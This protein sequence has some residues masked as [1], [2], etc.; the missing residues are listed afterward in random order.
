VETLNPDFVVWCCV[1]AVMAQV[2]VLLFIVH[3][4]LFKIM[5]NWGAEE[6]GRDTRY[7]PTFLMEVDDDA[8]QSDR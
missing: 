1:Q 7:V 4:R 5:R 8:L 3:W 2:G 6:P